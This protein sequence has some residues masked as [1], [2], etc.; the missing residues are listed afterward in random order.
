MVTSQHEQFSPLKSPEVGVWLP[1][2]RGNWK[3]PHTQPS[4]PWAGMR[5]FLQLQEFLQI[6][7][8]QGHRDR[9]NKR[10]FLW[11]WCFV[12]ENIHFQ[13]SCLLG[14]PESVKLR[15]ENNNNNITQIFEVKQI[16]KWKPQREDGAM[17]NTMMMVFR[18][19]ITKQEWF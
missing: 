4:T 7:F 17:N 12:L 5:F 16:N 10:S 8:C 6:L 14:W 3:Q 2:W 9:P 15:N 18:N 1:I 11:T 19:E 13:I